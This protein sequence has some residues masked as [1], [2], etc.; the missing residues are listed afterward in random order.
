MTYTAWESSDYELYSAPFEGLHHI[1][2][3]H[4][5][6]VDW[7]LV[8]FTSVCMDTLWGSAWCNDVS[9][10]ASYFPVS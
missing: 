2:A 3:A 9:W 1:I 7:K 10:L 5:A 6:L 8:S 4:V